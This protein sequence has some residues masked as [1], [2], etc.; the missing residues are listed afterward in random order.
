MLRFR[1]A[2]LFFICAGLPIEN[3]P[4]ASNTAVGILFLISTAAN[5]ILLYAD[6]T[7][8]PA[9]PRHRNVLSAR[10]FALFTLCEQM[11][12]LLWVP[13]TALTVGIT[14]VLLIRVL[15]ISQ[16]G[17]LDTLGLAMLSPQLRATLLGRPLPM[18]VPRHARKVAPLPIIRLELI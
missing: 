6:A 9:P 7:L 16:A 1:P 5:T 11:L 3:R 10:R 13:T 17:L 12:V 15:M 18:E 14:R 4:S 2:V 8:P